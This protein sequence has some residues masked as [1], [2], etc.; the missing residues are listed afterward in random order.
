MSV[1]PG[2]PCRRCANCKAG[3]MN[4]CL[5]VK[6][7]GAPGSVGSLMRYFAL[8]ADM[9]PHLPESLSWEEA[10]SLQPLAIGVAI[11]IRA[12]LRAHQT[13]A[14]MG[15]GPIG[16]ITAAVAHAN[17]AKL[18]IGFDINPKRCEFARK[19]IS[20]ITGRP[21]F[22]RVFQVDSLPTTRKSA[23]GANGHGAHD[24]N[25]GDVKY[26]AAKERAKEYLAIMN[27]EADGVD[28][29]VEASGA[30]DAGLLGIA[31]AKQG[32]TCES[33]FRLRPG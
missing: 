9:A 12:D 20:P 6:Y 16:L 17:S 19:Y 8:P 29:V 22:D 5:D 23:N 28:R 32:A 2:L 26:D 18:I 4:I 13:L 30:E 11:G 3:R 1:E 25:V 14:I 10:G 21:I 31:I 33:P 7:C 15:C 27:V 24:E